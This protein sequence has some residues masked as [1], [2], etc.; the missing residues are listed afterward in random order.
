MIARRVKDVIMSTD[1][2]LKQMEQKHFE[3]MQAESE[4]ANR[5]KAF[6]FRLKH[7]IKLRIS[8]L[9]LIHI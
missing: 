5:R 8:N 1:E 7:E 4:A 6:E 3:L 9:S 2:Y